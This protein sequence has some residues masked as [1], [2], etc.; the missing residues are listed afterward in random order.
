MIRAADLYPIDA[1]A[2]APPA[3]SPA[4]AAPTSWFDE[5][6]APT[7][8]IAADLS[9]SS[10]GLSVAQHAERVLCHLLGEPEDR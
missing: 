8:C 10:R 3:E 5:G 7:L 6:P 4:G 1:G 2:T 9:A